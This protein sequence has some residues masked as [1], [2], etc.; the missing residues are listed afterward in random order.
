MKV[1]EWTFFN[2]STCKIFWEFHHLIQIIT[3][4]Y[5][6]ELTYTN[7][8]KIALIDYKNMEMFLESGLL[9]TLGH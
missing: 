5:E 7:K 3:T 6:T 2:T 8:L 4:T 1:R 9:W